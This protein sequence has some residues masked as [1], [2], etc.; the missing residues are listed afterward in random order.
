MPSP[1]SIVEVAEEEHVWSPQNGVLTEATVIYALGLAMVRST[2]IVRASDAL[3][4]AASVDDEQVC[5]YD[6]G[7]V[8]MTSPTCTDGAEAVRADTAGEAHFPPH[9][10]TIRVNAIY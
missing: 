8:V 6:R 3:P 2:I 5:C 1:G 9:N 7:C 10:A 4:L